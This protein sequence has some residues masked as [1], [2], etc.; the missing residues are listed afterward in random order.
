[1]IGLNSG[2]GYHYDISGLVLS[3]INFFD[4]WRVGVGIGCGVV[5]RCKL[6]IPDTPRGCLLGLGIL[7]LSTITCVAV[8]M[9]VHTSS[10]N[11]P[12][13]ISDNYWRWG[14]VCGVL[15]L[16]DNKGLRFGSDI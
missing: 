1:M 6:H 12:M 16:V 8:N 15:S 10:N 11:F 4:Y 14:K 3:V 2:A 7:F 13:D 9:A 5:A